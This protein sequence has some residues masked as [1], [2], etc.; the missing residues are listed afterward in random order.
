MNPKATISCSCGCMFQTA[1][2]GSS[3]E[4]PPQCPQCNAIMDKTS[5]KAL[6]D[7][8]AELSD[9]NHHIL[10]WHSERGEACMLVPAITV[11]TL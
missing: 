5:W 10:K 8:L 1:F 7:T 4:E 3:E 2:Q 9:F 11:S 6:R